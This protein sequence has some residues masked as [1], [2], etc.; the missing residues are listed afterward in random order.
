MPTIT[1]DGE[2]YPV[3]GEQNL[4]ANCLSQGIDLPYFCWHP[5]MGS[6]GA[7]RQCAVIEYKDAEDPH[8]KLVMAC[9][10]PVKDGGLYSVQ[11]QAAREFRGGIIEDLMT[12]HPHDCPVCEEGGE[13]HLQDMT[14][15]TGHVQR[16]YRGS[17]RT[18]RNQYLG[19]FINHEMNRCIACYRCT[20][21]YRDYAGG[22]DLESLGRNNQVY[23]GRQNDGMLENGFSGNLV[24]VCPTG[25]FTDKTFSEHYVRKWDLQT[26]PSICEHCAVGCNTAPG[27]REPGNGSGAI[28]RRITNLY[29]RDINGY[30][31]CDRGRFGYDY[32]NADSR[33]K[34]PLAASSESLIG[35]T[36]A[37]G[38]KVHREIPP[39]QA[40]ARL[41]EQ[42]RE[43]RNGKRR[44]FAIGSP[45]TSL[46]N[47]F[48]LR[49][50][51]GDDHFYSGLGERDLEL[52]H[53]I[54]RVQCDPR[55]HS[56]STPEI[57]S[58]D[59]VLI[60]GED[61]DNT[62][63]RISLAVRQAAR[64][65]QK[66][67][68]RQLKIPLWQDDS[69]R[70]LGG[71]PSPILLVGTGTPAMEEIASEILHCTIGQTAAFGAAVRDCLCGREPA[72]G[73]LPESQLELARRAAEM[74][75]SAERPL[76][77]SG[78]GSRNGEMIRASAAIACALAEYG[79]SGSDQCDLYLACPEMNSLGIAQLSAPD[80]GR[81]EEL[82]AK[83]RD[84]REGIPTTLVILENDLYRRGDRRTIDTMLSAADQVVLLDTLLNATARH[85]DLIFPAAATAESEGSTVNSNGVAQRFYAVYEGTGFI[86]ESWRWLA[87]AAADD[88]K[89][90]LA[91]CEHVFELTAALAKEFPALAVLEE[92]GP[93]ENYRIDGLK[94]ARQS[95]RYSGRTA[96]RAG[97]HV[98]ELPPH[99]D[100]DAPMVFSMEGIQNP[101]KTPLQ[102]NIWSPGW[103][104]NQS[105]NKFLRGIG[106]AR[107]G[108]DG[109]QRIEREPQSLDEWQPGGGEATSASGNFTT[110]P[111][112]RMFGSDE[113]SAR[114]KAIASVVDEPYAVL[115]ANDAEER[116][117]RTGDL[118]RIRVNSES[119][120]VEARVSATLPRGTL[121]V[122]A[123]LPGLESLDC[124]LPGRVVVEQTDTG[125][126]P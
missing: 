20:R 89:T 85:A 90:H 93:D 108:T 124:H 34:K 65:R 78:C 33:L 10:T 112:Y 52:L 39:E 55:I 77:I 14:E 53:L 60:L 4:L 100:P 94:V 92:T 47:N 46:E 109:G 59:A 19:P 28:L 104:S 21:F 76:I 49:Q 75:S 87:D 110:I 98:A 38:E 73:L 9:M 45:R 2:D 30:F 62:A 41:S 42:L 27:A 32:V 36:A 7:C 114:A 81:L 74:L 11:A 71:S 101:G 12:N 48:A 37:P 8:G 80:S 56:P 69:V 79:E 54:D 122:P 51:V 43:A 121:G 40:V 72:A 3:D 25:V 96:I 105:I 29:N 113:L 115:S 95:H 67:Q 35:S 70:Q 99:P 103:N 18:H 58:A 125:D 82:A 13:C 123:G 64:N 66:R 50:L 102:A 1:I 91:A 15:M 31:L 68:A 86:Q 16:R 118:L 24:E 63:P 5:A 107:K 116:H 83:L 6:V 57:E 106:G 61:I 44:L 22:E 111:L 84:T 126:T 119:Y 97:E 120:P 23:F 117:I 26:A 17:K 88:D